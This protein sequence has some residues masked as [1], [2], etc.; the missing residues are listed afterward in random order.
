MEP[1][2]LPEKALRSLLLC[3]LSAAGV[4]EY[5]TCSYFAAELAGCW[6]RNL[7]HDN[8]VRFTRRRYMV[9]RLHVYRPLATP[10]KESRGPKSLAL[11]SRNSNDG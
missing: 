7:L 1:R 10:G 3:A 5:A 4:L 9:Q 8:K 11:G 2:Q 6:L